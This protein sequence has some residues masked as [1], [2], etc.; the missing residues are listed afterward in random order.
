MGRGKKAKKG[1][2]ESELPGMSQLLAASEMELDAETDRFVEASDVDLPGSSARQP[3]GRHAFSDSGARPRGR[4]ARIVS[5]GQTDHEFDGGVLMTGLKAPVT[6]TR[7]ARASLI[8]PQ[9]LDPMVSD[10][11]HTQQPSTL[12][13]VQ[14]AR[15]RRNQMAA[16]SRA[17]SQPV[18]DTSRQLSVERRPLSVE[19]GKK[20]KVVLKAKLEALKEEKRQQAQQQREEAARRKAENL[21][22]DLEE[23]ERIRRIHEE[24][25]RDREERRLVE[26]QEAEKRRQNN[27]AQRAEKRARPGLGPGA[28]RGSSSRDGRG[29]RSASS[30][31]TDDARGDVRDALAELHQGRTQDDP[32]SPSAYNALFGHRPTVHGEIEDLEGEEEDILKQL[33]EY[34][35][36]EG[37]KAEDGPRTPSQDPRRE[38][39]VQERLER[40][41]EPVPVPGP[42]AAVQ[43]RPERLRILKGRAKPV[44]VP[45]AA[46]LQDRL[47][48]LR[49][50]NR[51]RTAPPSQ[52]V[53]DGV[54]E[55]RDDPVGRGP[56]EVYEYLVMHPGGQRLV[57]RARA[58][59][60]AG[61]KHR[62]VNK[63]VR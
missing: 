25:Q 59:R 46:P 63:L 57:R 15:M 62:R 24:Q 61:T 13:P 33:P 14:L 2:G 47:R 52:T 16:E 44:L 60:H 35:E 55:V 8:P 51:P 58:S 12:N 29:D 50:R 26:Q 53:T 18:N 42:G 37:M 4:G 22:K 54:M 7:M 30:A 56:Q 36:I 10:V 40:R 11:F 27:A 38:K 45:P 17:R 49:Q 5:G 1:T 6:A 34:H 23:N 28:S 19:E 9:P 39:S 43:E 21:A 48:I 20:R 31:R 41:I 3:I 32:W